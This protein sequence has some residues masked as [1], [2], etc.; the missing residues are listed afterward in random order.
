MKGYTVI[1]KVNLIAILFLVSSNVGA[2]GFWQAPFDTSGTIT[3]S[4]N[5]TLTLSDVLK[6]VAKKN[7]AFQSFHYQ[8]KAIRSDLK[9]AGLWSNPELDAEVEEFGWDAPGFKESELTIS[10]SQEFEFFGQRSARKKVASKQIDATELQLN[11]SAFDLYLETKQRFY[12]LAHAQ[13][14]VILSQESLTLAK[15]IVENINF[16]LERGAALQSE[17]L[18]AQLEEQRTQMA[19]NQAEQDVIAAEAILVSL[20]GGEPTGILVYIE[21]EPDLAQIQNQLSIISDHVDSTREIVQM[22]SEFGILEAEKEL[23]IREARPAVTLSGGFKRFEVNKSKSFLFG[24]SLPLPFFNRNQGTRESIDAQLRSMEYEIDQVR[25]TAGSEIKYHTIKLN[26]L[27]DRHACLD[28][29]ILPT[30]ENV[31]DKLQSAYEAGRVP[32]TQLLEAERSLNELNFEH[33]DMILAIHEQIIALENLTGI[34]LRMDME[35]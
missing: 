5:S 18:L 7:P 4:T 20:W 35:N 13:Q 21:T 9:Q 22:Y 24:V 33:N 34:A 10:I 26:Q 28:S 3:Q 11:L 17:L 30:A 1:L 32:Y 12:V 6:H 19:L 25:N 29:L 23:A 8:L 15:S 31:Y 2:S 16:R 27:V 14:L